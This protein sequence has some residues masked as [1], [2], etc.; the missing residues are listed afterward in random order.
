M[1]MHLKFRQEGSSYFCRDGGRDLMPPVKHWTGLM[2]SKLFI[3]VQLNIC[4]ICT[5]TGD[6]EGSCVVS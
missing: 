2:C 1:C 6:A 4:A 5:Y 3:V